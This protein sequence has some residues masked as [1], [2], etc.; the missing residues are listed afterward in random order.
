MIF[1]M[2]MIDLQQMSREEKLKVMHALW[3][4]LA[5]DEDTVESPEWHQDVLRDTAERV[6]LGVEHVRD[7]DEAKA[8]LRKRTE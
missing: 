4:D 1:G 5:R 6:R 8:E 3:E 7:W 2:T